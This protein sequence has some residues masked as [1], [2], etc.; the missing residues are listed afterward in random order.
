MIILKRVM[1]MDM[2]AEII[3]Q[4]PDHTKK[5]LGKMKR[6]Q[7]VAAFSG[8]DWDALYREARTIKGSSGDHFLPGFYVNFSNTDGQ[9]ITL[10]ICCENA[11]SPIFSW[12]E[13]EKL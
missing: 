10:H 1:K 9:T 8:I 11:P 3:L 12:R 7:A 6:V 13:T 4:G 5:T 2:R